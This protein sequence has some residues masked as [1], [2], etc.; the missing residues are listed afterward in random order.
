[1]LTR[2]AWPEIG[3][4]EKHLLEVTAGLRKK[5]H[6]VTIISAKNI[7]CP[8]IKFL[9]LVFIWFW[10][11]KN[12]GIFRGADVVHA[13]DVAIWYLPLRL[14]F[15]RKPF[16]VTFHGWE[17]KFPI[18]FRYKLIR[19]IAEKITLGNICVGRYIA[20]WYGTKPTYVIYGGVGRMPSIKNIKSNTILFLGRLQKDTGLPIYLS[21][22]DFIKR[23]H[24][25]MEV[26]FLGDG[27]LRTEV[28]KH[29]RVIGFKKDILPW[30]KKARFVFT[31][32]YLSMLEAMAAGKLVFATY[33]NKIKRDILKMSPFAK[34]VVIGNDPTELWREV[35]RVLRHPEQELMA[36]RKAANWAHRQR[37]DKVIDI[38]LEL[39]AKP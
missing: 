9:G 5:G 24:S 25:G 28:Q 16:Y 30:L 38:Y 11:I 6:T 22:L 35:D 31:S 2:R 10:M 13:H 37:W 33:N 27:P 39:W 18:P 29:G 19:K 14:L 20:K 8:Q 1:M 23:K 3:G 34:Y 4:V 15:P 36:T 21:A 7:R 17:G 32:G 12:L 26:L